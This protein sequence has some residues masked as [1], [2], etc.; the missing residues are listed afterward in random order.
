VGGGMGQELRAAYLDES[1]GFITHWAS[2]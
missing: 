1:A 2:G